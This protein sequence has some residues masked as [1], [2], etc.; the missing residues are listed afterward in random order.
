MLEKENKSAKT[1]IDAKL[2][3]DDALTFVQWAITIVNTGYDIPESKWRL[4]SKP[5]QQKFY[6]EKV[7]EGYHVS[8][9]YG[10]VENKK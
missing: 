4:L 10:I 8:P 7:K 6:M 5:P 2:C 1:T 3:P 9:V